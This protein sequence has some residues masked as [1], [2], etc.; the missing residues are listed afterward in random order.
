MEGTPLRRSKV[1]ILLNTLVT[2]QIET[3]KENLSKTR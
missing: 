3:L 1:R 2:S